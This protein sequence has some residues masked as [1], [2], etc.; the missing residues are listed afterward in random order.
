MENDEL[1]RS[2]RLNDGGSPPAAYSLFPAS[3]SPPVLGSGPAVLGE[4][5]SAAEESRVFARLRRR[6][7]ATL[8]RQTLARFPLPGVAGRRVDHA[9]LGWD[10]LDVLRRL[11]FLQSTFTTDLHAQ[12]VGVVFGTFFAAL[13]LMLVFSSGV[14]LY[15]SLFRS[16]EIAFLLTTPAR[17]ERVFLHKFQDA[18]VLSSWGFALLGSPMLAGLRHGGR[19]AV[20]LLRLAAALHR[21]LHLYPGGHRGD[22]LPVDRAPRARQPRGGADDGGR[23]LAAVRR[24]AGLERAGR[25]QEQPAYAR[26]VP[27]DL[28]PAADFRSAFAAQLVAEHGAAGRGRRRLAP[29]RVVPGADDFQRP[30]LP[31]IGPVDGG[32]QLSRGLQR[33]VRQEA[34]GPDAPARPRGPAVCPAPAPA[35][36]R[37][38]CV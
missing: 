9:A 34:L 4:C 19:V 33:A 22:S 23:L 13:M 25:P 15:G 16:P 17:T 21:G 30:V 14:I 37:P 1:P 3:P 7:L 31:P 20:V 26:L 6:M 18:I 38:S 32:P 12:A 36:C 28:R 2:A 27:G 10:V 8:L 24:V 5:L 11:R 35:R 29:E